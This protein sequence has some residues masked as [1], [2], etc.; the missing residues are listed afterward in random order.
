MLA[1]TAP[2]GFSNLT[3]RAPSTRENLRSIV[4]YLT[5]LLSPIERSFL[6]EQREEKSSTDV[7][8]SLMLVGQ[9]LASLASFDLDVPVI[10]KEEI[11]LLKY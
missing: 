11:D 3:L 7:L 5:N 2:A 8:R 10:E 4:E 9:C 6:N 1:S